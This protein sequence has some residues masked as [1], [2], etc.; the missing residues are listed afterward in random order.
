MVMAAAAAAAAVVVVV[1]V[2]L[3]LLLLFFFNT[4]PF[5]EDERYSSTSEQSWHLPH[6]HFL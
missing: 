5:P 2:V 4:L 1:V 3:L 6:C